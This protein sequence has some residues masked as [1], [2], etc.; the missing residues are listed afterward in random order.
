MSSVPTQIALATSP[1]SHFSSRTASASATGKMPA[2][3]V[4]HDGR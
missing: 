1:G 2:L 3:G 4:V